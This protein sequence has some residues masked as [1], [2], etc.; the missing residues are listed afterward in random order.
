M[1]NKNN[2]NLKEEYNWRGRV[3]ELL[4]K[5]YIKNGRQTKNYFFKEENLLK[6]KLNDFLKKYWDTID[7]YK[8]NLENNLE[9]Y[10]VK[11]HNFGIKRKPDL[12]EKTLECY[13][14]AIKIGIKV[15]VIF[16]EI[17][18]DWNI[19]FNITDFKE[20]NF[21]INNGGYYRK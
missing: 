15:K 2:F 9:I 1:N 6:K 17:K 12:T 3:G 16:V 10:E 19:S 11:T 5:F 18:D 7:L 14:N 21:R 13:K 4:A 8:I 20:E